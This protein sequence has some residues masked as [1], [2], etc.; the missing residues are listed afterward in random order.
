MKTVLLILAFLSCLFLAIAW[1][2]PDS[3]LVNRIISIARVQIALISLVL[4]VIANVILINK[5]TYDS[6]SRFK[7]FIVG[8]FYLFCVSL[9]SVTCLEKNISP[10]FGLITLTLV[11]IFL[12]LF[13]CISFLGYLTK[14]EIKGIF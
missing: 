8:F 13:F 14:H 6:A 5:N 4:I 9:F 11:L 3:F 2:T 12:Y 10:N 7:H 1:F